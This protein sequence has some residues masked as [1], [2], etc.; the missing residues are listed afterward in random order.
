MIWLRDLSF[1]LTSCFTVHSRKLRMLDKGPP[2]SRD[3]II[4]NNNND[5][6]RRGI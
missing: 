6:G 2:D 5:G 1:R 4:K 3:D